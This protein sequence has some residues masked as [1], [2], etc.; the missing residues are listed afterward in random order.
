[1]EARPRITERER[2]AVQELKPG[3]YRHFKGNLYQV[4]G[5]AHHSETQETLVVYRALYG[6]RGLWV[7][8]LTM[9]NERVSRGGYDGPRFSYV[10]EREEQIPR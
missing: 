9:W 8:P 6:E 3:V 4:L 2:I 1:M 7:R 10:C 5:V